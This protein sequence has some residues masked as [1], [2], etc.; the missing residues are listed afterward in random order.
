MELHEIMNETFYLK[1][2]SFYLLKK[3][4]S[5]KSASNENTEC[6]YRFEMECQDQYGVYDINFNSI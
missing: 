4:Y 3:L 1:L 6:M 2:Q 5:E